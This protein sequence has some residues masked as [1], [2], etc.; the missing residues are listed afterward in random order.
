[1]SIN[2]ERYDR[3]MS[4]DEN[5]DYL[6]EDDEDEGAGEDVNAIPDGDYKPFKYQG[7][8]S[9]DAERGMIADMIYRGGNW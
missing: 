5:G 6:D 4:V 7:G 8:Y 3:M 9:R 2:F 1:M